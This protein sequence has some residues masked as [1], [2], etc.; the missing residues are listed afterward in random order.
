MR[1]RESEKGDFKKAKEKQKHTL[2]FF[3]G[4]EQVF[5]LPR[6]KRKQK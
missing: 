5:L 3:G 1:E 2:T 6:T 4:G